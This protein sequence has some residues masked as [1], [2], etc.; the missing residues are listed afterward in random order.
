MPNYERIPFHE[1]Y[2][3]T[4]AW[5]CDETIFGRRLSDSNDYVVAIT[6]ND[7]DE[8][9]Y[10]GA[11]EDIL[12][13]TYDGFTYAVGE[14]AVTNEFGEYNLSTKEKVTLDCGAEAM[15]FEGTMSANE[16]TA[17]VDYYVYGYSFVYDGS[18]LTVGASVV[19]PE[20]ID[21]K[22]DMM[23]DIVDRMVKTVRMQP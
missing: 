22:K 5:R 18:T 13:E 7:E 8:G 14:H 11:I 9:E 2:I 20:V 17:V 10:T 1:I 21:E 16:Y 12:E 19:N 6:Y 23:K 15:K 4:P 3:S